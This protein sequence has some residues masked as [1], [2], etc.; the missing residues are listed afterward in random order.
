MYFGVPRQTL[1]GRLKGTDKIG[2]VDPW[3]TIAAR[4]RET[5]ANNGGRQQARADT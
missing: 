3:R 1:R 4:T 2:F 5:V